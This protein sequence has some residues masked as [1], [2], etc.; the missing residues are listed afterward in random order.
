L[1]IFA[2]KGM[3][4]SFQP[5]LRSWVSHAAD[6][7]FPIQN[8]PFGMASRTSDQRPFAAS[9]I[10]DWVIDL[11]ALQ[12]LDA[13]NGIQVP[14]GIFD[15]VSLNPFIALGKQ[16]TGLVRQRIMEALREE[17][18]YPELQREHSQWLLPLDQVQ[19][20]LPVEIGDYTDFYSSL[21][22]ATNVGTMF[23]DAQNP[24]LPNWK[25]MPIGYH[26]RASSICISGHTFH[27][28]MGQI[29][30]EDGPP[31]YG[32]CRLLD[33]E[34]E[35][36]FVI[37]K[38][39]R[40]GQQVRTGEAEEYIFGL[41]LFNDWSARDIQKWE[42]VPLGPFLGKNFASTVSPWI[43]TLDALEPFRVQGPVQDPEVLPYL[44]YE[45][46]KNYDLDLGVEICPQDGDPAVVC[47]SNY[48]YMYWNMCQQLAHHTV[49]GC[50]I[51]V[52]DLYASGTISGPEPGSFGSMLELSWKGTREVS[53][54]QGVSRKFILDGDTVVLRGHGVRDGVRIGFGECKA[55]VLPA[56]S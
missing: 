48:K 32:P 25:H 29:K 39:T 50:N 46:F 1:I 43:V 7:D 26:G 51:R 11:H 44:A 35:M 36:G 22:H 56:Q 5:G 10:G 21:E 38:E 6:T 40:M 8:I 42:Y 16:V 3:S 33:F 37:G 27:R 47:R 55:T 17:T 45:G 20:H 34:L 24:L 2:Q 9:I 28:P 14:P 31:V 53:L 19:H 52:G 12:R 30:P 4:S 23:R 54:Q 41:L 15:R 49:N 18:P 13:F